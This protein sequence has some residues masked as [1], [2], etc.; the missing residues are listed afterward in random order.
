MEEEIH[1]ASL[2]D[3]VNVNSHIYLVQEEAFAHV[4]SHIEGD[5][6]ECTI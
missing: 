4:K 1:D 5:Q 2:A 6:Y 3:K